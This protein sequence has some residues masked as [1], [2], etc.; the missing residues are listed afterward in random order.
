MRLPSPTTPLGRRLT[1]HYRERL[2]T[3]VYDGNVLLH[4]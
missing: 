2:T 1:K 3:Y 4:Q